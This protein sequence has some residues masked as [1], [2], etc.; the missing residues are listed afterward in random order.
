MIIKNFDLQKINLA[1]FN[2]FLFYGE[3]EGLKEDIIN[4]LFLKSVETI[5]R[6]D[7][8]EIIEKKDDIISSILN[9]SFFSTSE[10]IL[11]SRVSEK[12]LKF[13]DDI[14]DKNMSD[15]KIVLKS[16]I[17]SKKSALRTF[18][19]KEKNLVCVPFYSDEKQTL[20][21]IV[22]SF[23]KNKSVSISQ[24]SINELVDICHGDRKNLENELSKVEI[25]ATDKKKI[26]IEEIK[27]LTNIGENFSISELT[28]S[29]LSKNFERT[30]KILNQNYYTPDDC[31]LII[32]SLLSKSKRLLNLKNKY[33]K[34]KNLNLEILSH[35]PPI[36]WKEKEIIKKQV[37]SWEL[38]EIE[39]LIININNIEALIKKNSNSAINIIYD[40][41][42]N[43]GKKISN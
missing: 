30:I 35:K 13:I 23:F 27:K 12:I 7:E 34:S 15:V 16:S 5:K 33:D 2:L 29:C 9:K 40:F 43:T 21:K 41:I 8:N 24:E 20:A 3:N 4:R 22:S 10:V 14:V 25:Y 28:D 36:F 31:M 1:D 26:S 42:L 19:E 38:D 39:K 17:L 37:L 18:F 32:R 6:Y 11:I